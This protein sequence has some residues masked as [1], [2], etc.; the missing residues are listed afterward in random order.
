MPAERG[1]LGPNSL[2]NLDILPMSDL[3]E[4]L[5]GG[6]LGALDEAADEIERLTDDRKATF[7]AGYDHNTMSRSR[8]DMPRDRIGAYRFWVAAVD[9]GDT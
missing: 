3:I 6:D 7:L 9:K 1:V 5:R 2:V 4:R 8:M